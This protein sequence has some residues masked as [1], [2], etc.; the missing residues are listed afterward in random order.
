MA[1]P[2]NVG[3]IRKRGKAPWYQLFF[4]QWRVRPNSK[5]PEKGAAMIREDRRA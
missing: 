1:G 3:K 4:G 2:G 5:K